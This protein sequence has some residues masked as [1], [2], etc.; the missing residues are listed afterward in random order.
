MPLVVS[1]ASVFNPSRKTTHWTTPLEY[2]K[3]SRLGIGQQPQ[4]LE[5]SL[6]IQQQGMPQAIG[7]A[8]KA[9]A[10]HEIFFTLDYEEVTKQQQES[11]R[12][13][14]PHTNR[15]VHC[16]RQLSVELNNVSHNSSLVAKALSITREGGGVGEAAAWAV[17]KS[18][19]CADLHRIMDHRE[20]LLITYSTRAS[21]TATSP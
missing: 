6:Y 19:C 5:T 14:I 12:C 16:P 11:F 1:I 17:Q 9:Q 13:N 10:S 4:P 8:W 7:P 15:H 3:N 18:G 21:S 2:K 20:F